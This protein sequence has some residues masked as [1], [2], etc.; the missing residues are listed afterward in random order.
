MIDKITFK[1]DGQQFERLLKTIR[2]TNKD[3]WLLADEQTPA[4]ERKVF[5]VERFERTP[6]KAVL[7]TD[8]YWYNLERTDPIQVFVTHWM[9][10]PE[11]PT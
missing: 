4:V 2:E 5:A 8:G 1:L 3:G 10:L 9:P 7:G 6:F 11:G